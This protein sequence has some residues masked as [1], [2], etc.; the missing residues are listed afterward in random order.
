[1]LFNAV[2]LF[3]RMLQI[4]SMLP[5]NIKGMLYKTNRVRFPTGSL[6]DLRLWESC[7]T[8]PLVGG[9]SRGS[10]ISPAHSFRHCSTHLIS[11]S[12]ALK[13]SMSRAVLISLHSTL[14][15]KLLEEEVF[16]KS[17][18]TCPC[19]VGTTAS[20]QGE[21][22]SSPAGSL[23]SFTKISRFLRPF[24]PALL[25]SL[26]L[27]SSA[28]KTSLLRAKSLN[29]TQLLATIKIPQPPPLNPHPAILSGDGGPTVV[30]VRCPSRS[31]VVGRRAALRLL[32]SILL[33][34]RVCSMARCGFPEVGLFPGGS[35][36]ARQI[37][38]RTIRL[39][40]SLPTKQ[41]R[42]QSPGGSLRIFASGTRAGRFRWSRIFSESSR[43]S[44][45]LHS[46]A[47][48]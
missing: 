22:G 7:R 32:R 27:S 4:N 44:P 2:H 39:N 23:L 9:F 6:P 34:P 40:C 11:S 25:H 18:W 41:K 24:I 14:Q 30:F 31:N 1:M 38:C 48:P 37:A 46:G 12:S 5:E 45:P 26:L 33:S 20:H 35:A 15:D 10:P 13:S 42:V 29:S 43:F 16:L 17:K 19:S 36:D 28:L 21:P 3:Q 47:D 8:M